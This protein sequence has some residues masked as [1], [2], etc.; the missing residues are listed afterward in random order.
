MRRRRWV[1]GL[2]A[3]LASLPVFRG[4]SA[5]GDVREALVVRAGWLHAIWVDGLAGT[6]AHSASYVLMDGRGPWTELAIEEEVLRRA[7]GLRALNRRRVSVVSAPAV[8]VGEASGTHPGRLVVRSIMPAESPTAAAA[9]GSTE[10]VAPGS[11]PWITILCQF[12]DAAP[13]TLKPKAYFEDLMS[14]MP[15]GLDHYWREVSYSQID[16]AGSTVVGWYTL[17]RGR[18]Y[19]IYDRNG[20]GV[21]ASDPQRLAEDCTAAADG[22]VFFPNFFGINMMFAADLPSPT[23]TGGTS[24]FGGSATLLTKDGQ[25]RTWPLTWNSLSYHTQGIVAH[26]MGHGFGLPHSSGP[27]DQIY[28]SGWD[29]MSSPS[30]PGCSPAVADPKLG[31]VGVHTISFHKDLLGWIPPARKLVAP[32]GHSETILLDRLAQPDGE[33]HLMIQI[34]IGGS[35]T[36]FYTVEARRFAGY[37]TRIP[38]EAVV[39]HRVDTVDTRPARVVDPDAP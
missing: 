37:D 35:S 13:P 23:G 33:G 31:C 10:A 9:A 4:A 3:V 5:G 25:T 20:N 27:Y 12:P 1:I 18:S 17:P 19:Y 7:G 32:P 16:L 36:L 39:I 11:K 26:E 38:G 30:G 28:D 6:Q 8:A 22:G 2:I 14:A 21:E 15:P 34:P 24:S 29:V